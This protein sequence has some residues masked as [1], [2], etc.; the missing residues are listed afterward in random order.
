MLTSMSECTFLFPWI[1]PR[2]LRSRADFLAVDLVVFWDDSINI[3][4]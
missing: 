4:L 3:C 1:S 2:G